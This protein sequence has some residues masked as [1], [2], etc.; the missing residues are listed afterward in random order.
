MAVYDRNF[1][2][3]RRVEPRSSHHCEV[4]SPF[5]GAWI[6]V[7]PLAGPADVDL[8][9]LAARQAI[10][11][12]RWCR[13][14]PEHRLDVVEGFFS[15][16]LGHS[17][18][19]LD[20]VTRETGIPLRCNAHLID[21]LAVQC[22]AYF[23]ASRTNPLAEQGR[24]PGMG[25]AT[26]RQPTGVVVAVTSWNAPQRLAIGWLVPA[27]LAGCSVILALNPRTALDG[28]II[29]ELMMQAGL[30]EG[31][32]SILVT[33]GD[34]TDYLAGHPGVDRVALSGS[35]PRG[36]RAAAMATARMKRLTLEAGRRSAAIILPDA[37]IAATVDG[38]CD[39]GFFANGQWHARQDRFFVP[40]HRQAELVAAL[41]DAIDAMRLG[42]PLAPDTHIGPLVSAR[43][44]EAVL[45]AIWRGVAEGAEL[46]HGGAPA[47]LPNTLGAFVQPGVFSNVSKHM[48]I[49]RETMLGPVIVVIPYDD[50][51]DAIRMANDS[52]Y[53][54]TASIWTTDADLGLIA[55]GRL[56]AGVV[57]INGTNPAS[58][59]A[60]GCVR[61]SGVGWLHGLRGIDEFSELQTL[62]R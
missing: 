22:L 45:D 53:G 39:V 26:V 32:L 1:I 17:S 12:G 24:A 44:R 13:R 54:A 6:G 15:T 11:A 37:D 41:R 43:H 8:A 2:G 40:R 21:D 9:I 10:D 56:R 29:G 33:A 14:P 4:R 51:D 28:Q 20:L 42:D 57:S 59:S 7:A 35:D 55:A 47:D 5:D 38:L 30:P 3:G 52:G 16:Y 60:H 18:S 46:V 61:R 25:D 34:T 36:R 49:A 50:I 58:N 31:V 23:E 19:L 27:L 62:L 48:Q